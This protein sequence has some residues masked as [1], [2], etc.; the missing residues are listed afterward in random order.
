MQTPYS[1]YFIHWDEWTILPFQMQK[2]KKKKHLEKEDC[3]LREL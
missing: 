1:I 3:V 2:K